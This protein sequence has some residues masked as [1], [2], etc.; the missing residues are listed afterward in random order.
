MERGTVN[1]FGRLTTIS[2]RV[3]QTFEDTVQVDVPQELLPKTTE[4]ASVYP[5]AL[6]LKPGRYLLEIV[7]KDVNGDRKGAWRKGIQVPE[8]ADDRLENS[9]L[10]LADQ[11]HAV[12]TRSV[13][14]GNFVIGDTYVR[15]R[16]PPSHAV[17]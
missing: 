13:G 6:P 8:F 12:A 17:A 4:N 15:P 2:G 9:S 16:V 3:A 5:K 14:T 11:M 7:V 10:I 1:I